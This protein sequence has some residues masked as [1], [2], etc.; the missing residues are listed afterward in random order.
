MTRLPY[1]LAS[2]LVLISSFVALGD[3]PSRDQVAQTTTSTRIDYH[4]VRG[5]QA[6]TTST[7]LYEG[8]LHLQLQGNSRPQPMQQFGPHWSGDAHMLWGGLVNDKMITHFDLKKS[9]RYRLSI[10]LT[11]APDYGQFSA[12][13]N[14]KEIAEALDLYATR[15]EL[16]ELFTIKEITLQAGKQDLVFTLTGGNEKARKY[17]GTGYL[18][19][20]DFIRLVDLD[21]SK[22]IE[23]ASN[24]PKSTLPD[25][26]LNQTQVGFA[27]IKPLLSTYCYRCHSGDEPEG[28]LDLQ[29]FTSKADL[30]AN[31]ETTQKIALALQKR[32]MPPTDEKQLPELQHKRLATQFNKLV[33]QYLQSTH[34]LEPVVMRRLN[35]YEYNNAVRDLLKLKGDV[36]PLPEKVI[37]AAR[38]YF[39]PATGQL[40]AAVLIGNRT[41]GKN[42]IEKKFLTGVSPFAIDLQAEH[43]FNNRGEELSVSPILLESFLKLG[44]SIVNSPEFDGYSDLTETLF[45]TPSDKSIDQQVEI[46]SQRLRGFLEIAFRSRVEESTLQRYVNFFA[47]ELKRTDNFSQSMKNVVSGVLAS[48]RF[49]YLMEQVLKTEQEYTKAT[50]YELATRLSFFLWSSIPDEE[51]LRLAKSG[52]LAQPEVLEAQI[53]RMLEDRRSQ[54]LSENFARQWLRL[55]QLITAVPDFER[56]EIYYSRIGC[57]QWKFGMQMMVEPLLLF[58]SIMVEDRSIMLLVDSNYSYRSDELQAWYMNQEQFQQRTNSGRFNVFQQSYRKQKL[59]TRRQGGVIT[60]AAMLTMTS[61]PLRTQPITRGAWVLTVIFNQPPLPPP[62]IVPEI[63]ADDAVIEA[64]GFTL[65]DRLE[66]HK[67]NQSCASC[68][69]KIDPL[70]FAL[71]NYDAIG[72]WRDT[73]QSG[74]EIDASGQLFGEDKFTDIIGLKDAILDHPAWFMRAFSEHLL[75]YSLGRDLEVEDKPAVDRILRNVMADDGQFSTV[76]MQI[77]T[78]YPFLHK[79]KQTRHPSK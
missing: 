10:Q 65:R 13:L 21:P 23:L 67:V 55:D 31:I 50:P 69:A 27:E 43:G 22:K 74:L 76:V 20:L 61:G 68:H 3:E 62:D 38:P 75:S 32:E 29:Q 14:G 71:E 12:Q 45:K 37:R 48:P 19:G 59:D 72:R 17:R 73:F 44:T 34:T 41:I 63:E 24:Q 54:A 77:A 42:Q 8:E 11:K 79:S 15:V 4:A 57:E 1:L 53:H 47:F 52:E 6:I 46:A 49:L 33:D 39:D 64:Q 40:P 18:M 70:G 25:V 60:S 30:L 2:L 9:G 5:R 51:L 16:A 56:F 66:Q 35:R 58:E 28:E 7:G 36:Y 78:S 26:P